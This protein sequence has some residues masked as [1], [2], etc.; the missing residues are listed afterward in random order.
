MLVSSFQ[1]LRLANFTLSKSHL[2][3]SEHSLHFDDR[4]SAAARPDPLIAAVARLSLTVAAPS[5]FRP[6]DVSRLKFGSG[7]GH[8]DPSAHLGVEHWLA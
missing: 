3:M 4:M 7:F 6:L 8:W 1:E 2:T 5:S